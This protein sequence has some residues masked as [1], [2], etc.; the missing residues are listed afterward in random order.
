MYPF[1]DEVVE[2]CAIILAEAVERGA[3]AILDDCSARRYRGEERRSAEVVIIVVHYFEG[4]KK[5]EA[6]GRK[7]LACCSCLPLPATLG[8]AQKGRC[9]RR[10][11]QQLRSPVTRKL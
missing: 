8:W 10:C 11:R 3:D 5:M 6:A 1:S 2:D 7:G 9:R 4:E